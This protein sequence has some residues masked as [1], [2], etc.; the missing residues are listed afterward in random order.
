M[1]E[2]NQNPVNGEQVPPHPDPLPQGGEGENAPAPAEV[3]LT[4]QDYVKAAAN[5]LGTALRTMIINRIHDGTTEKGALENAFEAAKNAGTRTATLTDLTNAAAALKM[6]SIILSN[7]S[8]KNPDDLTLVKE[9]TA[10][11]ANASTRLA[12]A[13]N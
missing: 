7:H 3:Q 11:A 12:P 8:L 4:L 10:A 9:A 1:D 13:E 2:E 6:A 5:G